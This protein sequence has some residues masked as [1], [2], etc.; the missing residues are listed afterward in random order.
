MSNTFNTEKLRYF[1]MGF[2]LALACIWACTPGADSK[3]VVA[4][5]SKMKSKIPGALANQR[6]EAWEKVRKSIDSTL[7]PKKDSTL[8][9]FVVKGFQIQPGEFQEMLNDLGP[10]P[11]VWAMLAISTDSITKKP[12]IDLIFKGRSKKTIASGDEYEYYDFTDPCPP[13]C[14]PNN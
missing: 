12:I 6:I 9:S 3:V 10:D 13:S 2:V 7:K 1:F 8:K 11:Q 4:E 5:S 14:P